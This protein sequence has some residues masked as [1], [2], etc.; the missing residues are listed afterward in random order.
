M[1]GT[2]LRVDMLTT[3]LL[4]PVEQFTIL[5]RQR[6]AETAELVL[7]WETTEVSVPVRVK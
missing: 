3:R 6:N 5:F 2:F 7:Q 4:H 1:S